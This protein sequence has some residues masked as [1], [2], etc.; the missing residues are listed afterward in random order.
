MARFVAVDLYSESCYEGETLEDLIDMGYS[1]QELLG[2]EDELHNSAFQVTKRFA[3]RLAFDNGYDSQDVYIID[4]EK[5]K[6]CY[7]VNFM[8]IP[9]YEVTPIY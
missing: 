5:K 2:D 7:R 9:S 8:C 3:E 1:I 4:L 6:V